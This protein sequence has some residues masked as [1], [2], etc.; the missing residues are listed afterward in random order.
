MKKLKCYRHGEVLFKKID[1]LSK[2]VKETKSNII[3]Q[4]SH[5]NNHTFDNGKMYLQKESDF[6]FGYFKAKNT[7][8]IHPEHSPKGEAKLP[9]GYYQLLKQQE[10]IADGLKPVID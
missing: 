6:I 2:G 4:G 3:M 9:D 7:S 10:W 5:G 1:K 8:L